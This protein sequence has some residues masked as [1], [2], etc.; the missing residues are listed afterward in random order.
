MMSSL[1]RKRPELNA[2]VKRE[3]CACKKQ[4]P[5]TSIQEVRAWAQ[6]KLGLSIA[7]STVAL[8]LKDSEKWLNVTTAG[9]TAVRRRPAQF[10]EMEA[11]LMLW[12]GT[13]RAKGAV[14][15]DEMLQEKARSLGTHLGKLS[16]QKFMYAQSFCIVG[17]RICMLRFVCLF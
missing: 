8:I 13:V 4:R 3:I 6:H 10:E 12:F 9:S 5:S 14:V 11:A 16:I 17:F 7:K 15:S 2:G 1:K